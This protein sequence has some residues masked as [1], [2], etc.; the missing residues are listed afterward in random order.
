LAFR[1]SLP[2]FIILLMMGVLAACGGDDATEAP[3][4]VATTAAAAGSAPATTAAPTAAAVATE[5]PATGGATSAPRPTS[6][7]GRLIPT[8]AP[9]EA[10]AET[11][12]TW[13]AAYPKA[14]E[15]GIPTDVGK[16]T[17][18]MDSWGSSDLNP[19]GLTS[20]NFMH[21][22]FNLRLMMQDPNG[23][24]APAWALSFEQTL[25]GL[26]F[27]INPD[28]RFQDGTPAD[29]EAVKNNLLGFRGDFVEEAGYDAPLWNSAK[30]QELTVDVE[31]ISPT[32]VFVKTDGGKPTWM[33]NLGGN[34]Y[35]L[36]WYGNANRLLEG[37]KAYLEDPAGGGPF[38][39][40]EWEP[41]NRVLFNRWDDFWA[42]YEH[43]HRP[44]FAQMEFLTV[45]DPSARFALLAGKQADAVYNLPWALAVDL[46]RSEDLGVRGVNPGTGETWTQTYQ[47]NGM[48]AMTFGCPIHLR[49]AAKSAGR[50]DEGGVE[51]PEWTTPGVCVDHPTLDAN[52]R[53][54]LNLAIDKAAVSAGP[55]FG[56]SKPIG[57]IFHAGSFGSRLD[58][59]VY[60]VSEY[61][62]EEAKRLLVEAGHGDGF[63]MSGHFG[64]FAGRPG[65]PEMADAISS[66]W[67]ELGVTTTWQ[68][69]DPT[70]YV[71]GFRAGIF[72]QVPVNLQTWGRQDHSGVQISW[73][74]A[75]SGYVG[76][77]NERIEE[78]YWDAT[79]SE[80][81]ED[82]VPFLHE[83]EDEV[84]ATEETFPLYGMTLV[85]AY[86]DRVLSHPTVEFTPHFKHYD[87]VVLRD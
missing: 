21:D 60:N 58:E 85:N 62:P 86:S 81:P 5:A 47:A 72:A 9:T 77:Y 57:S 12:K 43:W 37:P 27:Q 69:H 87:L 14:G 22:Y 25:D 19:W 42:D 24:L 64:Q 61:D 7:A 44:Q 17:V 23:V 54:A 32:E 18:A 79:G 76:I 46:G 82:M 31:V 50:T 34:G 73:Y 70:D 68:E 20:V 45:S 16:F 75:T 4:P 71:R 74:H 15:N 53:R 63:E 28:A 35:H 1:L 10:V 26:T 2:L 39:I 33:W 3:A 49:E 29:A 78:L 6:A 40:E 59:R 84:L 52:V 67:N 55:H 11:S 83:L 36:Y 30:A 48:L 51:I 56:F 41:N 8:V 80:T 66:Y 65:I 38:S 13:P